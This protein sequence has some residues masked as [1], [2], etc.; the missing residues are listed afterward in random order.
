MRKSLLFVAYAILFS[1]AV[2]VY[3]K[4]PNYREHLRFWI[5]QGLLALTLVVTSFYVLLTSEL[6]SETRR[7]QQRPLLEASFAE[8][9]TAKCSNHKFHRLY[10]QGLLIFKSVAKMMG[11]EQTAPPLKS[12]VVELRNIGQA[13]ARDVSVTL[14]M[15]TP[16]G[17]FIEKMNIHDEIT[18]DGMTQIQIVPASLP[19]GRIE[20]AALSYG[21]G[22]KTYV[23]FVGNGSFQ[24]PTPSELVGSSGDAAVKRP[25]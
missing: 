4:W 20:I 3:W 9:E 22:L 23:E 12:L 10:E 24:N 15:I 1:A 5:P 13:T 14:K 16:N 7:L 2:F 11:G 8:V 21:D 6:V 17:A 25:G 18:K 19:W